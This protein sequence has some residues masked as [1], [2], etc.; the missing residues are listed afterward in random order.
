MLTLR[1]DPVLEGF[2]D[3][4]LREFLKNREAVAVREHFFVRDHVPYLAVLVT[5]GIDPPAPEPSDGARAKAWESGWRSQVSAEDLPLFNALREWRAERASREGIAPYLI[6]TNK[7]LAAMVS[8]RPQSLTRLGAIDGIGKTKLEKYGQDLLAM[9]ARPR[10]GQASPETAHA[11]TAVGAGS[12]EERPEAG[13]REGG[14]DGR[15]A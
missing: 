1:F 9:L 6:C 11:P 4:P 10:N 7:Q 2:D 15:T 3:G 13:G 14:P 12:A 8:A 5:Y